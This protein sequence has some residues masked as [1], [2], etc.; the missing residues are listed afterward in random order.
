MEIFDIIYPSPA[1]APYI[2]YYWYL[3]TESNQPGTE[4]IIPTGCISMIFHKANLL[5]S[6][7][8]QD[9]QPRNFICG[10]SDGY[11]NLITSGTTE[12][13]VVVFQPFG[14]KPFFSVPVNEFYNDSVPVEDMENVLLDDLQKRIQDEP[15]RML[16]I[17]Y[18]EDYLMKK[19][20]RTADYNYKRMSAV[21]N[22]INVNPQA[23]IQSLADTACLSYKQFGRIFAGYVGARPKEFS[24]V[25]RFQRALYLMQTHTDFNLTRLAFE[26]GY[27]DQPHLIREFKAFAGYTPAELISVCP[28]YSDYFSTLR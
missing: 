17:S 27:Y 19:L 8:R 9:Y 16:C 12:M 5:F 14:A 23:S 2:R 11:T 10:L 18:I 25:I 26:S 20:N 4:R 28:P 13:L 6:E 15:D 21:I 24:R 3:R 1:L 7:N 22:R